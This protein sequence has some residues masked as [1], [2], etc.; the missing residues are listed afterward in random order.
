MALAV[1][2]MLLCAGCSIVAPRPEPSEGRLP[3]QANLSRAMVRLEVEASRLCATRAPAELVDPTPAAMVECEVLDLFPSARRSCP[4][5]ENR[6]PPPPCALPGHDGAKRLGWTLTLEPS[7]EPGPDRLRTLTVFTGGERV[8]AVLRASSATPR[9]LTADICP[10]DVTG[11][12]LFDLVA[13]FRLADDDG[14]TATATATGNRLAV[15]VVDIAKDSD[16]VLRL[17]LQ[18]FDPQ[19]PQGC[20][21]PLLSRLRYDGERLRLYLV[22]EDEASR[23]RPLT[24]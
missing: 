14:A 10:A 2:A 11:D 21:S 13:L 3:E 4:E 15:E 6:G 17:S 7:P 19:E 20:Q 1:V 8:S 5:G 16:Q 18:R 23:S 12:G 9:W 24:A 22:P